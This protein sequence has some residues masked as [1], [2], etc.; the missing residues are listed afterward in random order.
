MTAQKLL[1]WK[2]LMIFHILYILSVMY[3]F[4]TVT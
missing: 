3:S 4:K 1:F 2:I